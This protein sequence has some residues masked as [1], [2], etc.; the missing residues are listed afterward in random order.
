LL[1]Q[2][3]LD[4]PLTVT[5][6]QLAFFKPRDPTA[7]MP[8]R[9]P[10][11]IHR[12]PNTTSLGSGF[13]IFHHSAVKMML[14][15]IGPHVDPDDPDHTINQPGLDRLRAY[16]SSVLPTLG[17]NIV[18]TTTCRYTMTPD[19]HFIIDRHPAYP[20]I[21]IASPCS[22]HGFKFGIVTGR[23][24]ADLAERGATEYNIERF[25]LNRPALITTAS[26]NHR[27]GDDLES[28]F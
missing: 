6:E 27:G 26:K 15:R 11:F 23:I 8:G 24:L 4:L 1:R 28:T 2:L 13:P 16:V 7:F 20:Q 19:E 12:F 18:E 25:R 3:E 10:L 14:D 22:G 17:D 21:V 5:K 9:F